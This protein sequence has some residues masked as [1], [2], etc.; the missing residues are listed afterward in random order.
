MCIRDSCEEDLFNLA[1][2]Y[3]EAAKKRVAAKNAASDGKI[4]YGIGVSLGVYGCGLDNSDEMCIRDRDIGDELCRLADAQR[5]GVTAFDRDAA[6]VVPQ[7]AKYAAEKRAFAHAVRSQDGEEFPVLGLEA[8]AV[9]H[10]SL[11]HI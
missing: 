4:K 3:Y 2:P 11:I 6:G 5:F 7:Q 8:H 1:R 9:E 10:L